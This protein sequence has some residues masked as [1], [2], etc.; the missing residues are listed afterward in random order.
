MDK[1]RKYLKNVK[2]NFC[3]KSRRNLSFQV[4]FQFT[5]KGGKSVSI[6]VA[7]QSLQRV[8]S[9]QTATEKSIGI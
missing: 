3:I 5:V 4:F 7:F 2:T 6:P 8:G 9:K 1:I